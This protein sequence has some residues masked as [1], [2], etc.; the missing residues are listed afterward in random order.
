MYYRMASSDDPS[1]SSIDQTC[2]AYIDYKQCKFDPIAPGSFQGKPGRAET[3]HSRRPLWRWRP[4]DHL[5]GWCL[6][7]CSR[8]FCERSEKSTSMSH[9]KRVKIRWMNKHWSGCW[10][11]TCGLCYPCIIDR[12]TSAFPQGNSKPYVDPFLSNGCISMPQELYSGFLWHN[13]SM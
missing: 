11:V 4:R 13:W 7:Y 6:G 3:N 1:R 10:V 8:S 12:D 5:K 9:M 2:D